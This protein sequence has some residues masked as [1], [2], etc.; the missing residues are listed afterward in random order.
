MAEI[1][2]AEQTVEGFAYSSSIGVYH[3]AIK[4]APF[5]LE[6]DKTY[7]VTWDG[8]EHE[9]VAFAFNDGIYDTVAIGDKLLIG[10]ESTGEN[11]AI[12]YN[13]ST[14]YAN[15]FALTT[16]ESHTISITSMEDT[17]TEETVGVDIVLYDRTGAA[18]TYNN[19]DTLITD[20]PD[21]A[22][23]ATFTYGKA[24]E[25][26]EYE[27]DFSDGN[28]KVALNKGNLLK[29]FTLAKPENLA[30][31]YIKK[32][33]N[34]AGVVGEFAGDELVKTVE[35]DM[36]AGDQVIEADEDTVLT[37]VT[38]RK[39]ETLVPENIVSGVEIG[40]IAGAAPGTYGFDIT[41]DMLR[42]FA[43]SLDY[44]SRTITLRSIDY[45]KLYEDNVSYDVS[46]P[47]KIGGY[48]VVI[49]N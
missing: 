34:I 39:P 4:P 31:E 41:D 8:E 18:V 36:A 7:K 24:V 48:D 1:I 46:I 6:L 32:N 14:D 17:E 21:E 28:Q 5:T 25:N 23:G 26:A 40:G 13:L 2:F 22:K 33:I 49:K 35:L 11:F 12:S 15:F 45:A 37:K 27:L 9:L 43:Y 42:Y 30:P 29:E 47:D 44:E 38:V 16:G 3:C 10:K 20:T 19:T